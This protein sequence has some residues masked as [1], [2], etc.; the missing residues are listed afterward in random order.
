MESTQVEH[1][2]KLSNKPGFQ[3]IDDVEEVYT[4]LG[5]LYC[6]LRVISYLLLG[7]KVLFR[8]QD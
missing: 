1:K 7:V 5:T 2:V 3:D 8:G 6:L 4:R